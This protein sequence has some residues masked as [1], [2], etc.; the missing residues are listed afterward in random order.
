MS[1]QRTIPE[2]LRHI[3]WS[4]DIDALDLQ[5]D[6]RL[7]IAQ[8]LNRGNGAAIRWLRTIYPEND[9]RAVV[10]APQ[11]GQWFPQVLTFW[12]TILHI[13]LSRTL[14]QKALRILDPLPF[15]PTHP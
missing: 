15:T 11:R 6:K 12:A 9:L 13:E 3:F 1:D 7:I 14:Y 8:V 10:S 2:T 4:Y 5:R